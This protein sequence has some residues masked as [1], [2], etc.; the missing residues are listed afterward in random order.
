MS[1][2]GFQNKNFLI[3]K[4]VREVMTDQTKNWKIRTDTID[5]IANVVS[6]KIQSD[7]DLVLSQSEQLIDF[8][9]QLLSD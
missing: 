7:P 6:E 5:E 9:V 3:Q 2:I 4:E 8:F 1:D